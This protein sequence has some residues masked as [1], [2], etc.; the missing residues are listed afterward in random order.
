MV[1]VRTARRTDN[2]WEG[3]FRVIPILG[4]ATRWKS[5]GLPEGFV[6][7]GMALSA[8]NFLGRLFAKNLA[9]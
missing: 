4:K 9:A 2:R 7:P 8:A 6:T 3:D 5:A 1:E